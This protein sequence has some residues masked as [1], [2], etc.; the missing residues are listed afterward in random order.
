MP[1][2]PATTADDITDSIRSLVDRIVDGKITQELARRGQEVAGQLAERGTEIGSLAEDA[3]RDSQPMRRDATKRL[4][5]ASRDTAKW[6]DRAWR[7][8]LRPL[9]K[10]LW[11]RR[12]VAIGAAATAVP[13]GREIID[14]TAAR[15]GLKEREERRWGSFFFGMLLGIAAGAIAAMLLTPKRGS[16]MRKELT[17]RAD[18]L[19][20]RAK[21][22]W[23]PIFQREDETNGR[24]LDLDSSSS[25]IIEGA[26]DAGTD[27]GTSVETEAVA[28][29]E[30]ADQA[31]SEAADAIND[32]YDS[33]ESESP[34]S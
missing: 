6:S 32:A 16:E 23:V 21:D 22:E 33:A 26:A 30:T 18:E 2:G 27:F 9:L 10:D 4:A 24:S 5:R 28:T 8:Q 3:W 34:T 15:L 12:T 20:T 25:R 1:T 29:G 17:A 19:A 14:T 7:K 11:N 13:A 31:A